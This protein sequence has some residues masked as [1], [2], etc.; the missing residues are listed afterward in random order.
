MRPW[1]STQLGT[2]IARAHA[3]P[4][5]IAPHTVVGRPLGDAQR[6]PGLRFRH[7]PWLRSNHKPRAAARRF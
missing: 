1:T 3:Q 6:S 7:V 5:P 4:Q 2:A